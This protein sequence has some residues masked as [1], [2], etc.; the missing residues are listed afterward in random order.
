[1]YESRGIDIAPEPRRPDVDKDN[2]NDNDDDDG[3]DDDDDDDNDDIS[4]LST[5]IGTSRVYE[6]M[7]GEEEKMKRSS[8][9]MSNCNYQ[10][11]SS[12][13]LV[14]KQNKQ[15]FNTSRLTCLL[16]QHTYTHTHTLT[17]YIYS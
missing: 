10:H 5:V 4:F 15:T 14:D 16:R 6:G 17:L 9:D 3:D 1:V 11:Q 7:T 2:D 12:S 13:R 8:G